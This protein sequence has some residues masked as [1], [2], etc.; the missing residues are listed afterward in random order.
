MWYTLCK[1]EVHLWNDCSMFQRYTIAIVN[2]FVGKEDGFI[3]D[4]CQN[5]GVIIPNI[6]RYCIIQQHCNGLH[7]DFCRVNTHYTE[8]FYTLYVLI[9]RFDKNLFMV[10]LVGVGNRGQTQNWDNHAS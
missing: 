8:S 1:V 3:C 5:L 9:E 6:S 7:F 2:P 4:I 10:E